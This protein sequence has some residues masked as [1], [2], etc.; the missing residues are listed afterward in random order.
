MNDGSSPGA[1]K[2]AGSHLFY[3]EILV[4][5]SLSLFEINGGMSS[6]KGD[7]ESWRQ[8][9][10]NTCVYDL[11]S[12]ALMCECVVCAVDVASFSRLQA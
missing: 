12:S 9:G 1:V 8:Y 10:P 3:S 4:A 6:N 7:D 5:L 2:G 11:V